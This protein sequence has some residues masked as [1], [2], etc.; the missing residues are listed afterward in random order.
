[1]FAI[2]KFNLSC[3]QKNNVIRNQMGYLDVMGRKT[4]FTLSFVHQFVY[5]LNFL[6]T[7]SQQC[8]LAIGHLAYGDIEISHD[9]LWKGRN[10]LNARLMLYLSICCSEKKK[11][12][13]D[14]TAAKHL[15]ATRFLIFNPTCANY[16][17]KCDVFVKRR[18]FKL[19]SES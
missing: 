3:R 10:S 12:L 6:K 13:L 19:Y 1:M 17:R 16:Y 9:T 4:H 15:H 7:F 11:L 14:T 5:Q 18:A 2:I 8:I